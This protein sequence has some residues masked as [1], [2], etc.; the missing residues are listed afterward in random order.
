[1]RGTM[2]RVATVASALL[3]GLIEAAALLRSRWADRRQRH[4]ARLHV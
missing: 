3:W 2:L 4:G 1:M